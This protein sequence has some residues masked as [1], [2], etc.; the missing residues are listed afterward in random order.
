MI[1]TALKVTIYQG[2][3]FIPQVAQKTKKRKSIHVALIVKAI[4]GLREFSVALPTGLVCSE[5]A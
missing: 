5:S 2:C 4:M 1:S 3:L